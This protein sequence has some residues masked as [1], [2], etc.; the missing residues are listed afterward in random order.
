[1]A[2]EDMAVEDMAVKDMAVEEMFWLR[3]CLGRGD[4]MV[5][6]KA[7]KVLFVEDLTL[8]GIKVF[9]VNRKKHD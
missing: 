8:P 2:V 9:L 5:D 6:D 7:V 4:V 1:M 3:R